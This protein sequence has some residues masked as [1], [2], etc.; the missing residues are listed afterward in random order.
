MLGD[1]LVLQEPA[2]DN[3][4]ML[5]FAGQ[6]PALSGILYGSYPAAMADT[7]TY[8]FLSASLT[9]PERAAPTGFE[10]PGMLAVTYPAQNAKIYTEQLY[11]MGSSD[12]AAPLLLD[13]AEV[14]ADNRA[15]GGSF[16]VAVELAEGENSFTFTQGDTSVTLKVQKATAAGGTAPTYPQDHTHEAKAGQVI[17][18]VSQIASALTVPGDL[19][20]INET[21]PTG[22]TFVA[23]GSTRIRRGG[24]TSWAYQMP[25]GDWVQAVNCVWLN[26]DGKSAFTGITVTADAEKRGEWLDFEGAGS[27]AAYISY[28]NDTGAL[29]LTFYDTQLSVPDGFSSQYVERAEVAPGEKGATVLTL[30]TRNLWGYNIEYGENSTR[31]FLKGV[32]RLSDNPAKPLLGVRVMLDPGHGDTDIG[33]PGIMGDIGPNEKHLNLAQAQAIAYRLEQLGAT[34]LMTRDGDVFYE[35]EERLA[36]QNEQKPDFFLAVHHNSVELDRDRSGAKGLEAYYY[37]PYNTP[38]SKGFAQNLVDRISA[39]SGRTK[40]KDADYNYFYVTRS[41]VCPS[42][43]FEY[44]FVV[45]PGEFEDIISTDSLYT[46]AFATVE[47]LIETIPNSV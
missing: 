13:G 11:I 5:F 1:G 23:A 46:V 36:M 39:E 15:K 10:L 16:G 25:S 2:D 31:L 3:G 47:A 37:H 30:H 38:P 7:G 22:A 27:P 43:L 18:V 21:L 28:N 29:A 42:V 33:A 6:N 19:S 24:Y 44:G 14:P 32:P 4:L 17:K 12:P 40:R 35:L 34:V 9:K 26:G 20:A 41:T 45:S 8:A